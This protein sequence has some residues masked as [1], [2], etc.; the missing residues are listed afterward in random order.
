MSLKVH[1]KL[2]PAKPLAVWAKRCVR[3]AVCAGLCE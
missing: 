3:V 2:P 1:Q